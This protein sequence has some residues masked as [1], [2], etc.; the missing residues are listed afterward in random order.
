MLTEML[1][2]VINQH[3]A[4][5]AFSTHDPYVIYHEILSYRNLDLN[6]H[7]TLNCQQDI[8]KLSV[9]VHYGLKTYKCG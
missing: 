7:I 2:R 8:T 3:S 9:R 1:I 5:D 4:A 6:C